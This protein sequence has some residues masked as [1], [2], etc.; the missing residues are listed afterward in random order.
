MIRLLSVVSLIL[1]LFILSILIVPGIIRNRNLEGS[2]KAFGES[3]G[4]RKGESHSEGLYFLDVIFVG[5]EKGYEKINEFE[6]FGRSVFATNLKGVGLIFI[7]TP[8][9]IRSGDTYYY[10][11]QTVDALSY[12]GLNNLYNVLNNFESFLR[13]GDGGYFQFPPELKPWFEFIGGR[14]SADKGPVNSIMRAVETYQSGHR[15]DWDKLKFGKVRRYE[16]LFLLSPGQ[17]TLVEK[18]TVDITKL[19][20]GKYSDSIRKIYPEWAEQ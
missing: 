9:A 18:M 17:I 1:V 11:G 2:I 13:V 12:G 5:Y 3:Q 4:L 7:K 6:Y 20:D 19:K 15:G 16:E 14:F 8:I 10:Q